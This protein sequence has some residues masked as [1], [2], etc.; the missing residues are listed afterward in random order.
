[1][2]EVFVA[3]ALAF[4]MFRTAGEYFINIYGTLPGGI[5]SFSLLDL[6]LLLWRRE[7]TDEKTK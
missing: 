4:N 7:K 5:P 6:L 1:M 2:G 3:S